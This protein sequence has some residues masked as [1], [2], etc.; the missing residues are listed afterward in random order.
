MIPIKQSVS[1]SSLSMD[2]TDKGT[3]YFAGADPLSAQARMSELAQELTRRGGRHDTNKSEIFRETGTLV[4]DYL[5]EFL[6]P[7]DCR[8]EW[9]IFI[10]FVKAS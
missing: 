2:S 8:R 3:T 6:K 7:E 4:G 9:R 5:K 1:R 10:F